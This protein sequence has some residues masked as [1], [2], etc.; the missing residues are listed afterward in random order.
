[1]PV[2]A[3]D[4][5]NSSWQMFEDE[6][7]DYLEP[8]EAAKL[9]LNPSFILRRRCCIFRRHCGKIM[10]R[11]QQVRKFRCRSCRTEFTLEFVSGP[12]S[13]PGPSAECVIC[14]R[15]KYSYPSRGGWQE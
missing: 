8:V 3:C 2:C 10:R 4:H 9:I 14:G 1:M 13:S 15:V 5:L 6:M 7:P 12:V 11:V